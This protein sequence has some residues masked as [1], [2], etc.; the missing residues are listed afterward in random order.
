MK[1][2]FKTPILFL[3]FNRP[4]ITQLVFNQIKQ[5]RPT[6]LYVA[7]DGPRK[8]CPSDIINCTKTLSILNQIDWDC[9]VKTLVRK[10][11]LGCGYA[12]STAISWFFDQEESGIIIEDDCLPDLSFF[13]FCGELLEKY[14]EKDDVYLIS[15][16]NFQN[17]IKRG[18]GSYY[19]SNY[20]LTLG[21]A[22]WKRAWIKFKYDIPKLKESF[23]KGEL[24]HVFQSIPEKRYWQKKMLKSVN[25]NHIWD[26]QWFYT[27]WK[28]KGIG[29]T[30]NL[31]LVINIG[32][33]IKSTHTSLRDSIRGPSKQCSMSLPLI[34]SE[35]IVDKIADKFTFKHVYSHS[36][37]RFLRLYKEN[38]TYIIMM[39]IISDIIANVKSRFFMIKNQNTFEKRVNKI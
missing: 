8:N 17:G 7:A 16:T 13:P 22:T 36:F 25:Q 28:N 19:F 26:Y 11:N 24:D 1:A 18:M 5:I 38:G 23:A 6:Y 31:N 15:G 39:Y 27:I 10:E 32:F 33:N 30:S 34:H 9:E 35:I 2:N 20:A 12:V 14:K 37:S 3:I 21:W 29:I 4:D